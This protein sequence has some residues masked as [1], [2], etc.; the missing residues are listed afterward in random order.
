MEVR[1]PSAKYLAG[2]AFKQTEVGLIPED[3]EIRPLKL[4]AEVERGK[5]TARPRNDPK[6]YGGDIPFIQTG[7]ITNSNG[8]VTSYTQTLNKAGLTVSKLFPR[9]TLFFTIAANIGDVGFAAFDAACPDSVVA[10]TP[11]KATCKEWLAHE[12]RSR[13]AE[14]E[15]LATS[16]AQLNLNLEKLRPYLLP[17]PSLGEQKAIATAL[18]DADALIE[19]LEQLLAKKRQIKQGAMQEL[20]TAQRRLPGFSGEWKQNRLGDCAVLKARIGWQG[21]TTAEYLDSGNYYLVTGTEFKNGYIDWPSCVFIEESRYKQDKYI[22][23]RLHDVLVTKDGTI[24]K[25]ALINE[26]PLPATLNSGVF[27]IRP[28]DGKFHPEFFYYL[29]CSEVLERFLSQLSAGS[30]INHLYQ[31]DFVGFSFYQPESLEE[32][33]AIAQVLSD[34]DAD[35]AAVETRLNKARAIKQGMMQEL[36]TGRIRLVP[37]SAMVLP[38]PATPVEP[39]PPARPH[40]VQFEEAA[41][42]GVLAGMFGSEKFPLARVRRTKLLYLLH[43]RHEGIAEGYLKKAAGPYNHKTRYD[44]G[45]GI[46]LKRGYVRS[47]RNGQYEGLMAG[48][49]LAEA[50][51]YVEKWHGPELRSWLAQFHY[52]KTEAL[53]LLATVDMAMVEIR[54]SGRQLSVDAVRQLIAA[55]PE[56]RKK[57]EREIFSDDHIAQAIARSVDLFGEA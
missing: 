32:Q 8:V 42:L 41:L 25:I 44:G 27:V 20:L 39:P 33:T 40:N 9:G 37:P 1:E 7:D 5:F 21:L 38:F 4:L 15:N 57:L 52:E 46:A 13:K 31:K 26:L 51:A 11:T 28:I 35:I 36:L 53:E 12:L 30:T 56:W 14:F 3:W 54:R 34:M 16:N 50:E 23:L 45:E 6:Y 2:T 19:S 43:R 49:K 24:G 55:D 17:L 47:V 18:N 10:I 29:L 48:A 22:Q